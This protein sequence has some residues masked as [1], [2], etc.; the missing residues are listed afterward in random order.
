MRSYVVEGIIL[1][2]SNT[3]EADRILTLYT[4][5]QGKAK[6]LGKGIRRINSRR[7]GNLE[8]FNRVKAH[9]VKGKTFDLITEVETIKGFGAFRRNLPKVAVAY[10][11]VE[12]VER[13]TPE[14]VENQEV[15]SLLDGALTQLASG[16]E[17]TEELNSEFAV[18]LLQILG[19]WPKDRLFVGNWQSFVESII[20][21]PLRASKLLM[22]FRKEP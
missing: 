22:T 7:S 16:G 20:E 17:A 5:R 1:K 13:L 9:V 19:F 8:L 15:F 18:K 3:G 21:K 2:R 14:G 10:Q 4:K 11:L 12:L 6:L